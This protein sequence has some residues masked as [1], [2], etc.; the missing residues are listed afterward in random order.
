MNKTIS[1]PA[2][3]LVPEHRAAPERNSAPALVPKGIN[4]NPD[5]EVTAITILI[6]VLS[7]LE[8]EAQKRV[9]EY[10]TLRCVQERKKPK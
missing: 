6:N 7:P 9:L 2:T 5:L 3:K 1:R 4:R 10:V 8:P